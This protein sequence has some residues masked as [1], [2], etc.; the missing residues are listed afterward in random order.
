MIRIYTS[1]T[2]EIC[3]IPW[4]SEADVS[5][6][7]VEWLHENPKDWAGEPDGI[8]L[9]SDTET[10]AVILNGSLI[11]RYRKTE[12]DPW[13]YGPYP[14]QHLPEPLFPLVTTRPTA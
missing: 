10:Q 11:C 1:P 9:N 5:E 12:S 8:I 4:D 3:Q 2:M 13:V 7:F 6:E 14:L